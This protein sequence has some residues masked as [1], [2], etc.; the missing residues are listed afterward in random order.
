MRLVG[1]NTTGEQNTTGS[2]VLSN[3]SDAKHPISIVTTG[4]SDGEIS[5]STTLGLPTEVTLERM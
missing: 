3:N 2:V 5:L 4:H 1:Q